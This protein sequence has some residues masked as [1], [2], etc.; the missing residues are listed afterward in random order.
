MV[1]FLVKESN[2]I[3]LSQFL[4]ISPWDMCLEIDSRKTTSIKLDVNR[5]LFQ[6]FLCSSF[7]VETVLMLLIYNTMFAL[8]FYYFSFLALET[9][10]VAI[11][12]Q[13]RVDNK[14]KPVIVC[15]M[16]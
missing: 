16:S 3:S 6:V 13:T 1:I 14:D 9:S 4:F 12:L 8:S 2:L 15:I 10:V 11:P 7:Q 5:I